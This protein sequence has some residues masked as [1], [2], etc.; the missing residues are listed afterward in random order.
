MHVIYRYY[1]P[2]G[3]ARVS[4]NPIVDANMEVASSD[5]VALVEVL[6]PFDRGF[7]VQFSYMCQGGASTKLSR[8][9]RREISNVKSSSSGG[10]PW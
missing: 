4:S 10:A 7:D 3:F 8:I 9:S 1:K 5:D 2:L 6:D